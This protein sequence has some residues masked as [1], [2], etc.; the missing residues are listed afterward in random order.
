MELVFEG[1]GE[2][3]RLIV[4]R[5]NR[6]LKVQSNKTHMELVQT[7]FTNI[8][9]KGLESIEDEIYSCVCDECF[10]KAIIKSFEKQGYKLQNDKS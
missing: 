1:G 2:V 8:Y 6:I 3:V 10:K 9:D 5:K 4:D 7:E